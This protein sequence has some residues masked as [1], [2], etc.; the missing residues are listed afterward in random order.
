MPDGFWFW[1]AVYVGGVML[2]GILLSIATVLSGMN[3]DGG[4]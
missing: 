4:K 3:K 1:T 2:L